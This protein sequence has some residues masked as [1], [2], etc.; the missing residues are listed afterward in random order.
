MH[1]A[2]RIME[3][4]NPLGSRTNSILLRAEIPQCQLLWACL[5]L[6]SAFS[7]FKASPISNATSDH[8]I[9]NDP[10]ANETCSNIAIYNAMEKV[11][12]SET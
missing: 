12:R 3:T 6:I 10:H 7:R 8:L 1:S 2:K 5:L 9:L 11:S 4:F